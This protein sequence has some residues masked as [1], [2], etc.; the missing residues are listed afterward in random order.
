MVVVVGLEVA[1]KGIGDESNGCR[2]SGDLG[3]V[4][5]EHGEARG[6]VRWAP[7]DAVK[8]TDRVARS[9]GGRSLVGDELRGGAC[10]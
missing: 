9:L 5:R 6:V 2:S 4:A 8:L 3:L 7:G 1:G 10:R